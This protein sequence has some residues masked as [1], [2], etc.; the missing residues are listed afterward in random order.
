MKHLP[1]SMK[2]TTWQ[3]CPSKIGAIWV[4][5]IHRFLGMTHSKGRKDASHQY[6]AQ[7]LSLVQWHNAQIKFHCQWNSMDTAK[8]TRTH[9]WLL[10]KNESQQKSGVQHN[11]MMQMMIFSRIHEWYNLHVSEIPRPTTGW[12]FLETP[13]FEWDFN[14]FSNTH[15]HTRRLESDRD[16]HVMVRE[17]CTWA[18]QTTGELWRDGRRRKVGRLCVGWSSQRSGE[19]VGYLKRTLK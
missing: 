12:M 9:Y 13:F 6:G 4:S 17:R 11:M 5:G 19:K 15:T 14:W 7:E 2:P 10:S 3:T 8:M 18:S 16:Y 1:K